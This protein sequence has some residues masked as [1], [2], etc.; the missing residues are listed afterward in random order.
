MATIEARGPYQFR[1]KVRRNGVVQTKTFETRRAAEDWA[2]IIDGKVS[3]DEF[4]DQ[5]RA[6]ETTLS[7]ALD[8]YER[9]IVPKTPRSAKMKL[10]LIRYWR[11]SRFAK[12]RLVAL[13][14]WDLLE[15]RREVLDEDNVGDG[16][17]IGPQAEFGVQSCLHRLN[18][19]SHL[20]GQ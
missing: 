2:R 17:R 8:W 16:A 1:A 4:I 20:Y 19:I 11:K 10:G 5:N 12:W 7:Q 13:H 6:R 9:I 14:P 15:W 18:I 3:G